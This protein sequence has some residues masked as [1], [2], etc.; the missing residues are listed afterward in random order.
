MEKNNYKGGINMNMN[1]KQKIVLW[2][3]GIMIALRLFF[4]VE[5]RVIHHGGT[6]ILTTRPDIA[7][8]VLMGNTFL[9]CA[10]I[11]LITLLIYISLSGYRR[12]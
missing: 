2:I 9:Q 4:P 1:V 11:G 5:E 7:A 10:G 8:T 6:K 12:E 3:G